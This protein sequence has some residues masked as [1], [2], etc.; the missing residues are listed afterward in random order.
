MNEGRFLYEES[1]RDLADT[2]HHDG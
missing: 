2:L 1:K